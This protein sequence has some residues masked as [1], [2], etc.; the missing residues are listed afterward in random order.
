MEHTISA[1]RKRLYA[2]QTGRAGSFVAA[3]YNCMAKADPDNLSLIW[4]GFPEDAF[5]FSHY[6]NT[7]GYWE[8]IKH[9]ME[10]HDIEVE[11]CTAARRRTNCTEDGVGEHWHWAVV[12]RDSDSGMAVTVLNNGYAK[13]HAEAHAQARIELNQLEET[14]G[15]ENLR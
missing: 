12:E 1:A 5:V 6:K 11:I 15:T 3:L 8:G 10:R 13:T 4:R 2:W 9:E 7:E 14:H